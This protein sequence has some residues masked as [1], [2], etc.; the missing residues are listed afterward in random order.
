M[1]WLRVP[2]PSG[3]EDKYP[4]PQDCRTAFLVRKARDVVVERKGMGGLGMGMGK[5]ITSRVSSGMY[6]LV[7]VRGGGGA[8]VG[9]EEEDRQGSKEW[10]NAAAMAGGIGIDARK[11]VEN[12]LSLNR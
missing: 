9:E 10:G 11:Y 7:G 1:V 6:N 8:A 12:L 5:G 4:R 3:D 2:Q